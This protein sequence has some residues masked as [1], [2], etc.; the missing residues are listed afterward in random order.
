MALVCEGPATAT[1][2]LQAL[3]AEMS[4][5]ETLLKEGDHAGAGRRYRSVLTTAWVELAA[6]ASADGHGRASAQALA[7]ARWVSGAP[8]APEAAGDAGA[9]TAGE[10]VARERRIRE[11]AARAAYNLGV[12]AAQEKQFAEAGAFFDLARDAQPAFPRVDYAA[13]V[14]YF[15]ARDFDRAKTPLERAVTADTA[16][17]E[18]RRMLALVEFNLEHYARAAALLEQDP[19]RANQAALQYTYGVALVR[20]GQADKA[21]DVFSTLVTAHADSPEVNVVLGL[22]HAEQGDFDS[23]I[24]S[25]ERARRLDP[26][27]PEAATALGTIR[28]RQG[29]LDL[30]EPLLREAV[31]KHPDDRRAGEAL[32]EVLSLLGRRDEAIAQ[33]RTVVAAAPERAKAQYLL[34]KAL[35]AEDRVADAIP[36]LEASVRLAPKEASS[37]FQLAQAYRKA[38]DTTRADEEFKAYQALKEQRRAVRP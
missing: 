6:L 20:S 26:S 35:L 7:H 17:V 14:A 21:S 16:D 28:L 1:D 11:L 25:L 8:A 33:L 34:G 23:A 13:G 18:A 31:T 32:G 12:L 24:Q 29:R 30:A 22:A 5:A 15:N 10:R 4:Q 9:L 36:C 3:Q 2:P 19:A 38:G 27:V 37:R